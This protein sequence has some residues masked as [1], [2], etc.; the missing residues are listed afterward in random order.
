MYTFGVLVCFTPKFSNLP[1]VNYLD[2]YK[3]I[4]KVKMFRNAAYLYLLGISFIDVIVPLNTFHLWPSQHF[5][6][7]DKYN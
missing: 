5:A 4:Y 2:L 7:E 1:R 6:M 3:V